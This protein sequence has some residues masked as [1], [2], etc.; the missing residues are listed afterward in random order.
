MTV[1]GFVK[2]MAVGA[3][4]GLDAATLVGLDTRAD[5]T[6][7]ALTPDGRHLYA[8]SRDRRIFRFEVAADGTFTQVDP[9]VTSGAT[10]TKFSSLAISADGKSLYAAAELGSAGTPLPVHDRHG[11]R[12]HRRRAR[13]A[14]R[15]RSKPERPHHHARRA[16][17]VRHRRGPGAVRPRLDRARDPED[18]RDLRP[19]PAP[20]A[21]SSA[22]TRRPSPASRSPSPR[23]AAPSSFDAA[24]PR[25]RTARSPATTGTSATAP[26]S[27]TAVRRWRTCTRSP[28]EY[29]VKLVVTDNE[30]A[31]TLTTFT[32]NSVLGNGSPAAAI[33]RIVVVAA[34]VLP[35]TAPPAAPPAPIV[36][37]P[38]RP[39]LGETVIVEPEDGRVRVRLPGRQNFVNLR[40]LRVIPVGSLVDARRGK[41]LLSSVRDRSGDVQQ[42]HFSQG[43]FQVRQRRSERYLTELVL[44][45]ELGPCPDEGEASA[46][47]AGRAK[48]VGQRRRAASGPAAATPRARCAARAGSWRTPARARG[49]SSGAGASRCATSPTTA[50]R[51]RPGASATWPARAE[52]ARLRHPAQAKVSDV[53]WVE[54]FAVFG[55]CATW[56]ATSCS[57]PSGRRP[58]SSAG[59]AVTGPRGGRSWS[60]RPPTCWYSCPPSYGCGPSAGALVFLLAAIL[61]ATHAVE[62]DGRLIHWYVRRVKHSEP[63]RTSGGDRCGRPDLP[64]ADPLR[65]RAAGDGMSARPRPVTRRTVTP[66]QVLGVAS[67]GAVLA[68]VDATIVNV[69]FPDIARGL[70]RTPS[71]A[72]DLLGPQ[73][74]QHRVRRVHRRGR[75]RRRPAG[76]QAPLRVG[77]RSSSRW[78][79]CCARVAPSVGALVAARVIQ[80]LG[81]AIVVPASLALVLEAFPEGQRAHGVALWSAVAALAAGLG[82]SLGG[83]LVEVDGWRLVFLVNVP[84]G[85]V[86]LMLSQAH[87]GREP[88]AWPPDGARPARRARA[89]GRP[90]SP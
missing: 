8:S 16:Q 37:Q 39:E 19:R 90:P 36:A 12:A 14:C 71:L 30:G 26:P 38:A 69:A 23:P 32:G 72:S 59:S 46:A 81:A 27:R 28:G 77:H 29:E 54:V 7:V 49:R 48:A 86:A 74:L 22:P 15:W 61:F 44:R 13:R 66:R 52:P 10:D 62:D 3:D 33:T 80:A 63:A 51:P 73:R 40:T 24:R 67:L 78:R 31:S 6:D 41:A 57:R 50:A 43:L 35:L 34:P 79:R 2:R 56:P 18:A 17:P 20:S 88:R 4:G 55:V 11:R 9:P 47:R 1:D 60:T 84:V 64:R 70:R 21:S 85:I 5:L 42:G 76:P 25:T 83:V 75:A 65:P 58:G 53:S 87:S 82:P 68:F 89:R 45:G